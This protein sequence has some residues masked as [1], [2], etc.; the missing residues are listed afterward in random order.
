MK[1]QPTAKKETSTAV[2]LRHP[3]QFPFSLMANR[4]AL[5]R[6][7]HYVVAHFGLVTS[8]GLLLDQFRCILPEHTLKSQRENL[9][10]YSDTIG[11]AK[12]VIPAWKT[13]APVPPEKR[14]F[15]IP[16]VDF[17]HLA[18]WDDAYAEICFWNYSQ[19]HL[20]DLVKSGSPDAF[21]PW[22]VALIRCEIDLL[23]SFLVELYDTEV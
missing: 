12:R 11:V 18:N 8:G 15:T 4:F 20:S 16:V 5:E 9:V 7:E 21:I 14:E 22:G 3:V 23:R 19:A 10:Q 13:P 1:R 2:A 17:I 6:E